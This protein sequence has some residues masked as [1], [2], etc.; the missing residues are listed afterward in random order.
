ILG[1]I[2]VPHPPEKVTALVRLR[3]YS[4]HSRI[5]VMAE[6]VLV[7]G[8]GGREHA[9]AWKLAQSSQVQQVLVVPGNAGTAN[10]GKISNS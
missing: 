3:A 4:S 7:V 2:I 5:V 10:C 8:G 1:D 6:R 9:L